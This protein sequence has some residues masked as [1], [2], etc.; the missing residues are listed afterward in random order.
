MNIAMKLH[1]IYDCSLDWLILGIGPKSV[2][3]AHQQNETKKSI[4]T[5]NL[6]Q[7]G[8]GTYQVGSDEEVISRQ[9]HDEVV[10]AKNELIEILKN[11]LSDCQERLR[12]SAQ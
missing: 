12:R 8:G 3:I 2:N 5:T 6:Q 9:H 4:R 1:E 7:V 11:Q 10:S